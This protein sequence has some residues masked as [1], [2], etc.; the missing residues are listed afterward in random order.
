M[1]YVTNYVLLV[2]VT[3]SDHDDD[4]VPA[5]AWLNE[6][7]GPSQHG[8]GFKRVDHLAGGYKGFESYVYLFAGNGFPSGDMARLVASA[9][10]ADF[11]HI[12]LA[13][14]DQDA[15]TFTMLSGASELKAFPQPA[16]LT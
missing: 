3:E 1:S 14:R 15:N 10:W 5:I 2:P 7:I 12:Q 13:F 4:N 16:V 9:P 6:R 8:Q 11:D